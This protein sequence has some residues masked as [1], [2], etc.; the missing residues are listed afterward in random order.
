M[1]VY[2]IEKGEYSDR[3]VIG[4]VETEEEAKQV[5]SALSDGLYD[6]YY[7]EYDT[8]Q[9][10]VKTT[11]FAVRQDADGVWDA[12]PV[13]EEKSQSYPGIWPYIIEATSREQAI[14]IAQDYIP[15]MRAVGLEL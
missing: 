10:S 3:G 9:F 11:S 4:V 13:G 12:Q 8:K 5:C 15:K 14:K 6:A 2:V 1:K 7:T